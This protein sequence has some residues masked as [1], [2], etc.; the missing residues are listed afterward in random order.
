M[1]IGTVKWR[2]GVYWDCEMVSIGR[3]KWEALIWTVKTST[4]WH[5][6]FINK[7]DNIPYCAICVSTVC[8]KERMFLFYVHLPWH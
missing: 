6:L 1:Y 3:V 4:M 7:R 8:N 2:Y 5:T